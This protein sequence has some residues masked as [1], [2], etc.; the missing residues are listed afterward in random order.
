MARLDELGLDL[1][2]ATIT[3]QGVFVAG[4]MVVT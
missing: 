1:R 3:L 4:R 2:V